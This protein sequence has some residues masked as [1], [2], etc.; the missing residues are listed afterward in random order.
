MRRFV[1]S[2]TA[3]T[4][5]VAGGA[6]IGASAGAAPM[7]APGAVRAAADTLNVIE[8]V[9]FIWAGRNYCWYDDGW[10]GPGWYW[11]GYGPRV[12]LGWGGGFGWHNWRGGRPLV[13]HF[14]G[15]HFGGGHFGG[16][17]PGGGGGHHH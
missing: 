10:N 14:G 13:G 12:G 7:G 17:H 15:G 5:L 1:V 4:A 9:Q 8:D 16:G 11:C 3:A 2:I 6:M